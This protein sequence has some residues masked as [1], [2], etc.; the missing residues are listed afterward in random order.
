MESWRDELYHHGI[1]GQKWG[2]RRYQNPDGTLT[3]AGRKRLERQDLR[4]AKR[5]ERKITNA[6]R[7]LVDKDMRAY[8]KQVLK[9]SLNKYNVTGKVSRV[10][11]TA[12]SKMLA[13]LMNE[14]V[15]D[16]ESPSGRVV[17]FVA[18]RGEMGVYM[19]LAD[20][21]YDMNTVRNGVYGTGKIAYKKE[22]VGVATY[23][24][25]R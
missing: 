18:K 13:K 19:A 9:P 21:G 15:G 7:K 25:R 23:D 16:I 6:T 20:K 3:D 12:Y 14:R 8:E 1:V 17:R 22:N 11:G 2:V 4:W 10:Y 24:E 5:N